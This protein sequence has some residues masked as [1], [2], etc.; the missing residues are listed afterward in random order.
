M[1]HPLVMIILSNLNRF[2]SLRMGTALSW[3]W[4]LWAPRIL[5]IPL[6]RNTKGRRLLRVP[7][8]GP[9]NT[10]YGG[11]KIFGN[12]A[13]HSGG[14]TT[15]KHSQELTP[16]LLELKVAG[17]FTASFTFMA[18]G[19]LATV[20]LGDRFLSPIPDG[21]E[22]M[23]EAWEVRSFICWNFFSFNILSVWVPGHNSVAGNVTMFFTTTMVCY[24]I[25]W[26]LDLIVHFRT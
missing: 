21:R 5:Q 15:C 2:S 23:S 11:T 7:Q 9:Q 12:P 10:A 25:L 4:S 22:V 14:T 1:C 16:G 19:S 3:R 17:V 18:V 24:S 26:G 6:F 20:P 13:G 8:F